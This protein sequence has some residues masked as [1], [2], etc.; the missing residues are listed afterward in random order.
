MPSCPRGRPRYD[1]VLTPAE[2]RV[3]E[4]V[5]HGMSNSEFA[6]HQM[7]SVDAVKFHVSNL[8]MKLGFSSRSQ[9]RH[10]D[11]VQ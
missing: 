10:W 9:L 1:D 8:L 3:A 4:A 5:R 11:G 2:W 6:R 7:V